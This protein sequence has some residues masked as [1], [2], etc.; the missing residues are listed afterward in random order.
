MGTAHELQS[1]AVVQVVNRGTNDFVPPVI[2]STLPRLSAHTHTANMSH[3][4][5]AILIRRIL[6]DLDGNVQGLIEEFIASGGD[7]NQPDA[8]KMSL[9]M[10]ASILGN[11][12]V[13]L[14]LLNNGANVSKR[15]KNKMDALMHASL[16]GHIDIIRLLL[17]H[18]GV[19]LRTRDK[20]GMGALM[21]AV[22]MEHTAVV[23][24]LLEAAAPV[25]HQNSFGETALM[26]AANLRNFPTVQMLVEAG[27]D[28]DRLDVYGNTA[29]SL[30]ATV[31][32]IRTY[33]QAQ[34]NISIFSRFATGWCKH[35]Y[36]WCQ[37]QCLANLCFANATELQTALTR[38]PNQTLMLKALVYKHAHQHL[39]IYN[40]LF[41]ASIVY[42]R[43][44]ILQKLEWV[45][46]LLIE[47]ILSYL[48]VRHC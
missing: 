34:S 2:I 9:L 36:L 11:I 19:N 12:N 25:D 7:V 41:V 31:T 42:V 5:I 26:L 20:F 38:F 35:G 27:A 32:N 15:D 24:L 37:Q 16:N 47:H 17:V 46:N 43:T 18:E 45:D 48:P 33:L 44:H 1:Y 28:L 14:V 10:A 4:D 3:M 21:L 29:L 23:K 8:H 30:V 13:V 6:A 39:G 40:S 22:D